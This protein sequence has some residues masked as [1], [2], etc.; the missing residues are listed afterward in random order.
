MSKIFNRAVVVMEP[1]YY[2][3]DYLIILL[4]YEIHIIMQRIKKIF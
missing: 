2:K 4:S 3:N 1:K